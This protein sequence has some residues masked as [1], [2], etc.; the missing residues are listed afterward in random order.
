MLLV[1]ELLML[2]VASVS[3]CSLLS[4][5][6]I[7]LLLHVI[8]MVDRSFFMVYLLSCLVVTWLVPRETAAVSARF[9][10]CT[11]QSCTRSRQSTQSHK[12]RV[13]AYV[14]SC[15]LPSALWAE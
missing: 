1:A 11:I 6:L 9:V 13:A 14:F 2:L 8:Q 12:R 7:A 5:R 10:L 3:R 15:N 4:S